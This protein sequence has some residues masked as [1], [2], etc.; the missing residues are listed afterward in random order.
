ML[1]SPVDV[2][3]CGLVGNY[4][5]L[6]RNFEMSVNFLPEPQDVTFQKNILRGKKY[7]RRSALH[8]RGVLSA[9]YFFILACVHSLSVYSVLRALHSFGQCADRHC[10]QLR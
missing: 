7:L 4:A 5:T 6:V 3:S 2:T 9:V 1:L 8:C 10:I